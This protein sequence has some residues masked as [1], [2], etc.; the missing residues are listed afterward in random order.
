[1]D[2]VSTI[3]GCIRRSNSIDMKAVKVSSGPRPAERHQVC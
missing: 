2:G 1:M 3:D